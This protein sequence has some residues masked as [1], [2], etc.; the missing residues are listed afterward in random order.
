MA[1]R[2][3]AE[4]RGWIVAEISLEE[5]WRTVDHIKVGTAGYALLLGETS[6]PRQRVMIVL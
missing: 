2:H 1:E 3:D 6:Y 5:P 4:D